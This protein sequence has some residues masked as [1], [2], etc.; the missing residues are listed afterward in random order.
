MAT[1]DFARHLSKFLT[2]YLPGVKNLS[3]NTIL[4]YRDA[5]KLFLIFFEERFGRVPE[6]LT[7][8]M[9]TEHTVLEFLEWLETKRGCSPRTRNQRLAAICSFV[10]YVQKEYPDNLY[11]MQK[12]LA[13]PQK[14]AGRKT[15]QFLTP[16]EVGA[17]LSAPDTSKRAGRRDAAL[18]SLMY[19]SGARV[20]EIADLTV[21]DIR[22]DSPAVVTLHGKGN[23]ERRVPIM[24]KTAQ[25][26]DSYL[27]E[28]RKRYPEWKNEIHLFLNHQNNQLGRKG[29][30]WILKKYVKKLRAS[31]A[32]PPGIPITCHVLRH[33]KAAHMLQAGIPLIYIRDF[34]GHASVTTT[35]IY[36]RL[37]DKIKREAIESAYPLV[38]TPEYPSW[39]E[40]ANLM[41]WLEDL[42]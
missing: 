14:K 6:K 35:E 7:I 33:S 37:N 8:S 30:D 10:R 40:D 13:I 5:Y 25:L 22:T 23:I 21:V 41:A 31:G 4:S 39:I 2:V 28:H 12:I 17:I 19:D 29:I 34:L 15:I 24:G 3:R 26:L 11:E 20:Q 1:A 38:Q 32:L 36:A 9:L 18:L 27:Y 16:D 42:V